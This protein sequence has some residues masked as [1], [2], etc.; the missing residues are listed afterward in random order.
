ML[1]VFTVFRRHVVKKIID[2]MNDETEPCPSVLTD[3]LL[4]HW[5]AVKGIM[6]EQIPGLGELTEYALGEHSSW[7]N[8]LAIY[9]D[10]DAEYPDRLLVEMNRIIMLFNQCIEGADVVLDIIGFCL[11]YTPSTVVTFIQRALAS[12][13]ESLVKFVPNVYLFEAH[14]DNGQNSIQIY[15]HDQRIQMNWVS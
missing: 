10:K 6:E 15:S 9:T 5:K 14:L 12:L 3:C 1:F 13:D 11:L 4:D 7:I 2:K 8:A